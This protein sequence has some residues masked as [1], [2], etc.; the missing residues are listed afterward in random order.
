MGMER[1]AVTEG[2]GARSAVQPAMS[3]RV[4][5]SL[6]RDLFVD[7]VAVR[8]G[9]GKAGFVGPKSVE[10]LKKMLG[11][12]AEKI[13][14]D[15]LRWKANPV[16]VM[17][18]FLN[19]YYSFF[20]KTNPLSQMP[21]YWD[22]FAVELAHDDE[23]LGLVNYDT[24]RRRLVTGMIREM[25]EAKGSSA[26]K[27]FLAGCCGGLR[28]EWPQHFQERSKLFEAVLRAAA[29]MEAEPGLDWFLSAHAMETLKAHLLALKKFG[30]PIK[31]HLGN[32]HGAAAMANLAGYLEWRR[33]GAS[34]RFKGVEL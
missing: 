27:A 12:M 18:V 6:F 3:G 24:A 7:E 22:E 15:S 31:L 16:N 33:R 28:V 32:F 8:E 20:L 10:R 4:G 21:W 9:F 23:L 17:F 19:R 26:L 25:Q 13:A 11:R 14:E 1:S 5:V 34:P 29:Q 2:F 30:N